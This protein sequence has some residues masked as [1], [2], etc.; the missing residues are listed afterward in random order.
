MKNVK[1]YKITHGRIGFQEKWAGWQIAGR[2]EGVP[3]NSL[4]AFS[5]SQ[6]LKGAVGTALTKSISVF[7][8]SEFEG[9]FIMS[10][11]TFGL[12][13]K[14]GRLCFRSDG[15][16]FPLT[17]NPDLYKDPNNFLSVD[18]S[19]FNLVLKELYNENTDQKLELKPEFQQG[20]NVITIYN[21]PVS[22]GEDFDLKK[23]LTKYFNNDKKRIF[24][25]VRCIY[26]SVS[27][28]TPLYIK[29]SFNNDE[30]FEIIYLAYYVLPYS[31]RAKLSF[32]TYNIPRLEPTN[33]IFTDTAVSNGKIYDF[34]N[35]K[36]NVFD[37]VMEKA[38]QKYQYINF[39]ANNIE[40]PELTEYFNV[41]QKVMEDLG[42]ADSANF[43]FIGV[44]HEILREEEQD[45]QG[46]L[47][48]YDALMKFQNFL[49][50]PYN[51]VKIDWYIAKLLEVIIDNNIALNESI[52]ERLQA[53]LKI[54]QSEQLKNIGYSYNA[55]LMIKSPNRKKEFF[56]LNGLRE[57]EN[58]FTLMCKKISD[59]AGGDAFL[60]EFY[61]DYYGE[62]VVTNS[63]TL[64][65]FINETQTLRIKQ[66][67]NGFVYKKCREFG[68][69]IVDDYFISH[70]EI[71]SAFSTYQKYIHEKMPQEFSRVNDILR[72]TKQYFWEKFNLEDF[73][74]AEKENYC[75]VEYRT[76]E[77]YMTVKDLID[78]FHNVESQNISTVNR[79]LN[80][81]KQNSDK[82]TNTAK[83]NIIKEFQDRC[84][85]VNNKRTKID[86]WYKVANISQNECIGFIRKNDITVFTDTDILL[87]ELYDSEVF[88]RKKELIE[89][90]I[91]VDKY[92]QLNGEDEII[93]KISKVLHQFEKNLRKKEKFDIK[94][95]KKS[96]SNFIHKKKNT[97]EVNSKISDSF[98]DK[99]KDY[100][101]NESKGFDD[102]FVITS[103]EAKTKKGKRGF[104]GLG[105]GKKK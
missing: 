14:L 28:S 97:S 10:K 41:L 68:K 61:G 74:Y 77:K 56:Y 15:V 64:D 92:S 37:S 19:N 95:E 81:L 49:S 20:D 62:L 35:G 39:V 51:N 3:Q 58:L 32:R 82:L 26:W 1:A 50:L 46:E 101:E 90:I 59:E 91:A 9:N 70:T 89:F 45:E 65:D 85:S 55:I 79:F 42:G 4:N 34:D 80:I 98:D 103:T 8:L 104:L 69:K 88:S 76:S 48:D 94:N 105:F 31:L 2:S 75:A 38:Y 12:V 25:F 66:K 72:E 7:E 84:L 47:S 5:K 60:D 13:D 22:F 18:K 11:I 67:V 99:G 29:S 102:D 44:A 33:I 27:S 36:S 16:V 57:T 24:D 54:T 17:E 63:A 73:K 93:D 23:I 86:F 53:K 43:S 83:C 71:S 87:S 21:E 78:V 30:I 40:E 6:S 100:S 52:Q 96:D